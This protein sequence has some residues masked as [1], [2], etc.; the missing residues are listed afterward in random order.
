M[1]PGYYQKKLSAQRLNKVYDIAAPRVRQYLWAEI[2][3]LRDIVQP[4]DRIL[5]LGCG[6]GRV[7]V[8]LAHIAGGGWGIDQSLES[9]SFARVAQ[10]KLQW[11]VM[12]AADLGFRAQYFDV[13]VGVQNFISACQI[14]PPELLSQCLRVTR[15]GGQILFSSYT[16]QFWPHRLAW[17]RDQAAA[18]LIGAIDE[19]ATGNGIIMGQDG[20]RATTFSAEN[21]T[22]LT[23]SM[24]LKAH[25]YEVDESSV[26]CRVTAV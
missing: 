11:I 4:N 22:T 13:V 6:T 5:E 23:T 19:E 10:P 14:S 1:N 25:I 16:E 12:D 2:D 24:G 9:I 15:P 7:L 8:P 20:F 21:F 3:H 17:F 26:F 18:T